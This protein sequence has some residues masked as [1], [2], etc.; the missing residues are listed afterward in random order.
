[1]NAWLSGAC[2]PNKRPSDIG[3]IIG[4]PRRKDAV[5]SAGGLFDVFYQNIAVQ[6]DKFS[7]SNP[8]RERG[9]RA[10]TF[11]NSRNKSVTK[12]ISPLHGGRLFGVGAAT[13]GDRVSAAPKV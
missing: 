9:A 11:E 12:T 6:R 3:V 1:M 5:P 4:G 10:L 2:T 7:V 13:G 8:V